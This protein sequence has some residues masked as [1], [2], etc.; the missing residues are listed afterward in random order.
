MD[1][2]G[3]TVGEGDES[4]RSHFVVNEREQ[5]HNSQELGSKAPIADPDLGR[6]YF[7]SK[8]P[9]DEEWAPRIVVRWRNESKA[10]MLGF[11]FGLVARE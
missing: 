5:L 11:Y 9:E 6:S 4:I 2:S 10:P 3:C 7:L 1:D 8:R